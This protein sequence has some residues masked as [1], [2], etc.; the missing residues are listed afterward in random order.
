MIFWTIGISI[1]T[2]CS[3]NILALIQQPTWKSWQKGILWAIYHL[4]VAFI[5]LGYENKL[6]FGNLIMTFQVLISYAVASYAGLWKPIADK[7][8]IK[9]SRKIDPLGYG[10]SPTDKPTLLDNMYLTEVSNG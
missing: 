10:A 2:L 5:F 8:E 6:D 9:T 7:I 4:V 3:P 1:L